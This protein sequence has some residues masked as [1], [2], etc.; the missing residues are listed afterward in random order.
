LGIYKNIPEFKEP[1]KA[2]AR[3]TIGKGFEVS[4]INQANLEKIDG[5]GEDSFQSILTNLIITKKYNGDSYAEIIRNEKG[6]LINL[7]PLNPAN[8]RIVVNDKGLIIRY[9]ELNKQGKSKNKFQPFDIL[10]L[11]NDR[12]ANEIHGTPAWE[13]CK[14]EL[15]AKK[16]AAELWRKILRR[17]TMRVIYVDMDNS[18]KL[19]T[20][21]TQWKEAIKDGEVLLVPGKKGTDVEVVDYTTPPLQPFIDWLRYL[22]GRIY[23]SLGIPRAIADTADFSEA[24]SKVGYMTFEPVYTEEQTLLEQ[25]IWNQLGIRIKF[26]RPP[27]LHGVMQ[28]D[29]KKNTGQ[30]GM[31]PNEVKATAG[32]VE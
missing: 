3:W 8:V 2:L 11:C 21:K 13:A 7:K 17:S 16:E 10:H 25:D 15:E 18:T 4:S 22:D 6:T 5:W 27:S 14:W 9:E 1:I 23:Q 31:Q 28:E 30:V 29:E 20:L 19:T 24:A 26:N 32:R 12:I